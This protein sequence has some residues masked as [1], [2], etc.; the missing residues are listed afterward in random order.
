VKKAFVDE[1]PTAKRFLPRAH[2]RATPL[3]Q[4]HQPHHGRRRRAW[5]QGRVTAWD[6]K[7][8]PK[9][10]R[11]NVIEAVGIPLVRGAGVRRPA[12]RGREDPEF[13]EGAALPCRRLAHRHRAR[14]QQ[15][16]RSTSTPPGPGIVIGKKGAEIEK[17]KQELGKLTSRSAFSTSTKCGRPDLEAQLVAE[18]V[19]LQLERPGR[20]SGAP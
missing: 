13:L 6:R 20:R 17:L 16:P 7:Y 2:G 18:N 19:A 1:G 10:F 5:Q 4:A 11:L 12:A 9:G 15:R 3:V 14:R 8:I